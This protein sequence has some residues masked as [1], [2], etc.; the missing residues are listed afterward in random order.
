MPRN[1]QYVVIGVPSE[2]SVER[3]E[4]QDLPRGWD[5]RDCRA[6]RAFGDTWARSARSALLLVPSVVADLETNVLVNPRHP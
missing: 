4:P 6:S 3:C 1:Q 5:H 2:V